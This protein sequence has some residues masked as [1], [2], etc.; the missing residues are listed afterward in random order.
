MKHT[1]PNTSTGTGSCNHRSGTSGSGALHISL[2][3]CVVLK[4]SLQAQ[5]SVTVGAEVSCKRSQSEAEGAFAEITQEVSN[6][7]QQISIINPGAVQAI[8]RV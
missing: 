8:L 6:L 2:L 4:L 5:N 7:Q 3:N 1:H